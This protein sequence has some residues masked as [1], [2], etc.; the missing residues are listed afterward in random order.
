MI[1]LTYMQLFGV[2]ELALK[3]LQKLCGLVSQNKSRIDINS[4][5]ITKQFCEDHLFDDRRRLYQK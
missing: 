3:A 5:C 1:D 2:D 4:R